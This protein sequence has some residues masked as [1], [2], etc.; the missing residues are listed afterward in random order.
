MKKILMRGALSLLVLLFIIAGRT[1]AQSGYEY[2]SPTPSVD[3]VLSNFQFIQTITPQNE[4][5]P[6]PIEM[7]VS[8][9]RLSDYMVVDTGT[10]TL[11]P[12]TIVTRSENIPFSVNLYSSTSSA[13]LIHDGEVSTFETYQIDQ[14]PAVTGA[15]TFVSLHFTY[16]KPIQTSNLVTVLDQNVIMPQRISIQARDG[17]NDNWEYITNN[18]V[19]SSTVYF[20]RTSAREFLVTLSYN[21]P[22][23]IAEM[24]FVQSPTAESHYL[25]FVAR[26]KT[27]YTVY[28][29]PEGTVPYIPYLDN[30]NLTSTTLDT[31]AVNTTRLPNPKYIPA[32]T[33]KDGIT[34]S[35]DN[36][37][38]VAN[39]DQA[40]LN[41][42]NK[43][44]AC[45]DSDLDGVINATDNCPDIPNPNQQ[46]EDSDGK[47][48]HCD[49]VESRWVEQLS[50]L[51][52]IGIGVG[53]VVVLVLF[54]FSLSQKLPEDPDL[55][56][57]PDNTKKPAT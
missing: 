30:L 24:N 34:D 12:R 17:Q 10:N 16:E 26:P 32:D 4:P 7:P 44:D 49:G 21:Q 27:T 54:K 43:G 18:A 33:D 40:D 23:R 41:K 11:Q 48:D 15:T 52:W 45:E 36:C 5:L 1:Y 50:F 56:S 6:V 47:G 57:K 38:S 39:A 13:S 31:V 25:R 46:D 28:S 20:P 35:V 19:M 14:N 37:F 55:T 29:M 22:L 42:N 53:F 2:T 8:T 9:N 3:S 51:P